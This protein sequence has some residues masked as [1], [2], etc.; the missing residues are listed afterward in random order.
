MRVL[1]YNVWGCSESPARQEA[2]RKVIRNARPDIAC[3]QEVQVDPNADQ[4]SLL[5]GDTGFR[6]VHQAECL[7]TPGAS[8]G[9]LM[10]SRWPFELVAA[11]DLRLPGGVDGPWACLAVAVRPPRTEPFLFLGAK[12][13]WAPEAECE[14][15]EQVVAIA[16]LERAHRLGGA[17][18]IAGDFDAPSDAA[19]IRFL[20]GRQ[21]LQGKS[22][23]FLDAWSVAG[24]NTPGYTWSGHNPLAADEAER[25]L[26]Q[27]N[28]HRRN[29]Y[30]FVG[31]ALETQTPPA[32]RSC[33]LIGTEPV[34]R[35]YP[36]DHFGL[37]AEI[38]DTAG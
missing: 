30:I 7:A 26:G 11:I 4:A 19:S 6:S 20:T 16:E 34:D 8:S 27:R 17:T 12:P 10:A 3:F 31:P 36:S 1:T 2:L 32:I 21:S 35:V 23:F 37:L 22:T 33:K 5:L 14:R 18:I 28:F 9:I 38:A 24:N 25:I 29:D 13:S 15:E